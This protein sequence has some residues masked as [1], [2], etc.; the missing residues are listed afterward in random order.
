MGCSETHYAMVGVV[1]DEE[2]FG[3][4]EEFGDEVVTSLDDNGYKSKITQTES[5]LH[6]IVDG[7]NGDF[8]VF[9]K[10]V[11]KGLEEGLPFTTFKKIG[12]KLRNEI[13]EQAKKLLKVDV[14]PDD[15]VN[16][17]FTHWH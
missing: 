15:V 9:G 10:I 13:V 2:Q 17:A 7:M 1:F 5:G 11:A 8:M 3:L 6:L 4:L 16:V 12:K 14:D